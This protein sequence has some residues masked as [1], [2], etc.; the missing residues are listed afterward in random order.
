MDLEFWACFKCGDFSRGTHFQITQHS[1][2]H[3]SVCLKNATERENINKIIKGLQEFSS[4]LP[5]PPPP[6]ISKD[7]LQGKKH[8]INKRKIWLLKRKICVQ[9]IQDRQCQSVL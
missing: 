6:P 4:V 3:Q 7:L 5:P 8:G 1:Q 9:K 2:M